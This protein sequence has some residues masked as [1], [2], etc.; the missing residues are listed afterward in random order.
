VAYSLGGTVDGYF[1]IVFPAQGY[2][3]GSVS[4]TE[5]LG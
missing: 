4:Q 2:F 1:R 5:Y 3:L